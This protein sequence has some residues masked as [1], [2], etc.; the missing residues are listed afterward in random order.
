MINK[1]LIP[2]FFLTLL[3][4]LLFASFVYN[5]DIVLSI[6]SR[7]SDLR[8]FKYLLFFGYG[9]F[10]YRKLHKTIQGNH[11][12]SF[13]LVIIP[14]VIIDINAV[15]K[16][17]N[18]FPLRF[19]L[20]TLFPVSGAF[21][22]WAIE[23]GKRVAVISLLLFSISYFIFYALF[24]SPY[25][26]YQLF[27]VKGR[28]FEND[29]SIVLNG[30]F[31][32]LDGNTI[33]ISDS[34]KAPNIIVSCFFV[35]CSPCEELKTEIKEITGR[36]KEKKLGIVFVCDG[37][38]TEY[39]SFIKY[40]KSN[41]NERFLFLYDDTGILKEGFKG[42]GYPYEMLLCNNKI[43]DRINGFDKEIANIYLK[44]RLLL[45]K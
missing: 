17:V 40:V 38:S 20:V 24:L 28:T 13:I 31:K 29:E 2:Y 7:I 9:I 3:S 42:I 37:A 12:I 25:F 27:E 14:F 21:L 1:K 43:I 11:L 26:T 36:V 30:R 33:K 23:K 4:G 8:I 22:G 44:K 32:T 34:I 45:I 16:D 10:A 41:K 39:D 19:P 6:V 15:F 5:L 35:G 18:Y